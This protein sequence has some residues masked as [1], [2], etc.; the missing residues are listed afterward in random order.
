[1]PELV[2]FLGLAGGIQVAH[3][4]RRIGNT[5]AYAAVSHSPR[6]LVKGPMRQ[7]DVCIRKRRPAGTATPWTVSGA[8]CVWSDAAHIP[9]DFHDVLKLQQDHVTLTTVEQAGFGED[10]TA[11]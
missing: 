2:V 9:I 4:A 8:G 1:M 11:F 10:L 3:E 5:T 6:S 7:R